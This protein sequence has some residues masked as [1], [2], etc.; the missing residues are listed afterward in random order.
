MFGSFPLY[1]QDHQSRLWVEYE[2]QEGP[3]NGK[4]IVLVAG[5]EEYRSEESMPMLGQI[6]SQHHGFDCTVLFSVDPETGAIDPGQESHIPGMQR[7]EGADL[8]V[9]GLRYRNLP[10]DQMKYFVD[11]LGSGKPVIGFRTSTHAFKYPQGSSSEYRDYS[12]DSKKWPGGFGQ[13]VLGETWITH[14]GHHG[15]ES[16][17]GVVA[18]G[19]QA[20]PI[21]NSVEDVWG[22]TNV[23]EV[24]N[25]PESAT[26]LLYGQVLKGMNPDDEPVNGKKNDPMMPIA[27]IKTYETK[28]GI[29]SRVFC[30]TMGAATDFASEDFRR[31]LVN[32]CY[33]A[34]GLEDEIPA[35]AKVD[36]VTDFE[37]TPFGFKKFK[38]GVKPADHALGE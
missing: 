33:W 23:Y 31:L 37:P 7:I 3:G 29:S 27:W 16:T 26:V 17:R 22:P 2:G 36:F 1:A 32:A 8:V 6:L 24:N 10:D 35:E 13:Q 20:H 30:T 5:D 12:F 9:V 38:K 28:P 15:H 34:V 25:L 19:Q 21:L 14:H 4:R 11:Y 18:E